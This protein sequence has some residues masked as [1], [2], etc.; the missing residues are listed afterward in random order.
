MVEIEIKIDDIMERDMALFSKR[1]REGIKKAEKAALR[2]GKKILLEQIE[3]RYQNP[4]VEKNE[5]RI[6]KGTIWAR[7]GLL[8]TGG[9]H[10]LVSPEKY[11]STRGRK[12]SQ[13]EKA[14]VTIRQGRTAVFRHAF[15]VNPA[16]VNGG[17]TL[18]FQ[19]TG[20]KAKRKETGEEYDA[21]TPVKTV[22]I[23]EMVDTLAD[24]AIEKMCEKYDA[25]IEK[26]I[27]KK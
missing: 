3:K 23:P 11:E 5:L 17:N 10:F 18:L 9:T 7:S 21:I 27:N 25:Y 1:I 6:R 22:S 20:K 8:T 26:C 16:K 2:E 14:K 4:K 13:R 15:L 19:R 12:I 24:G